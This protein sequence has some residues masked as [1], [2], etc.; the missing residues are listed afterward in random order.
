M[1]GLRMFPGPRRPATRLP[2]RGGLVRGFLRGLVVEVWY[3]GPWSPPSPSRW[4][5]RTRSG[6]CLYVPAQVSDM[7]KPFEGPSAGPV[8]LVGCKKGVWAKG[9]PELMSWVCDATYADGTPLGQTMLQLRRQGG[10]MLASLKIADQ[11]GLKIE[12]VD[13]TP[14]QALASLEALLAAVSVPWQTDR[15]PVG[16]GGP[17]AKKRT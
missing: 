7:P 16:G 2:K 11:G 10:V 1:S 12:A 17:G 14:E 9:L 15:Y 4:L 6:E 8:A 3:R 13:A 5:E